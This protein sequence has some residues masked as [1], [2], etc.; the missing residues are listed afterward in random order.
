[1]NMKAFHIGNE[2]FTPK[3]YKTVVNRSASHHSSKEN[4]KMESVDH[5]GHGFDRATS[6]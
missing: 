1:M 4:D 3:W 5:S 2:Y 6:I